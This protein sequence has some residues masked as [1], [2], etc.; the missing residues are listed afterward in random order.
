LVDKA[1][2]IARLSTD[3]MQIGFGFE[4]FGGDA[5]VKLFA[6]RIFRVVVYEMGL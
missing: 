6:A 4:F 3:R 1:G 5:L 2:C